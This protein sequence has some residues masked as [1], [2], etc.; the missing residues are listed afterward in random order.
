M[1]SKRRHTTVRLSKD[2]EA[3]LLRLAASRTQ[4]DVIE[5]ALIALENNALAYGQQVRA[6]TADLIAAIRAGDERALGGAQMR[7]AELLRSLPA[8]TGIAAAIRDEAPDY[9][10]A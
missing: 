8:A 2:G 1:A 10:P 6:A 9:P 4:T 3:R 5:D 7:L